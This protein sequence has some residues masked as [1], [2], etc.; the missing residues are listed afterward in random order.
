MYTK[1]H[2]LVQTAQERQLP[3]SELIIEQEIQM[4]HSSREIIWA[5]MGK[6]LDVMLAAE[7]KGVTGEGVQSATGITGGEAVLMKRYREKGQ[8][9][10]GDIMLEAVQNAIATNEV[11]ASMGIICATPTAGSAGTLPGILSV[12]TKQLSLDRDASTLR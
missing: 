11:N 1:I 3:I 10:S 2:E 5:T 7:E 12:I 4:S 6:N 8:S 9:L